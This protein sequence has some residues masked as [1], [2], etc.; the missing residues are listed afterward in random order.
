MG[1]SFDALLDVVNHHAI[2][3]L[4]DISRGLCFFIFLPGQDAEKNNHSKKI[5]FPDVKTLS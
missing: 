4:V 1:N 3:V 5:I 2:E